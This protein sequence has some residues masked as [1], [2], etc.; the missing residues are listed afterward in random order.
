MYSLGWRGVHHISGLNHLPLT[1][2]NL[3]ASREFCVWRLGGQKFSIEASTDHG[4]KNGYFRLSND[5]AEYID[6]R[7]H[8][9]H[10]DGGGWTQFYDK[11][12][13]VKEEWYGDC[14]SF[15]DNV[16]SDTNM[17]LKI[18]IPSNNINGKP[19]GIYQDKM[20]LTVKPD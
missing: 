9:K 8:I 12:P 19:A 18:K 10:K 4:D 5:S 17:S 1:Q 14:K 13:Q 7:M 6:Y 3:E 15:G 16:N 11:R 2:D 20:T